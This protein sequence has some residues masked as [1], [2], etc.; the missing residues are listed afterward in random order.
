LRAGLQ[1]FREACVPIIKQWQ[2]HGVVAASADPDTLAQLILSIS[3]G[4][5]A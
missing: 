3:L 1:G 2:A 5:V 4:F